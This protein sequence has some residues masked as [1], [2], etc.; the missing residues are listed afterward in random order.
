MKPKKF[1]LGDIVRKLNEEAAKE[2]KKQE[3]TAQEIG[4]QRPDGQTDPLPA[5]TIP[6]AP[7]QF[8]PLPARA[9]SPET[10]HI[11]AQEQKRKP[12][13]DAFAKTFN[14]ERGV[15]DVEAR[16]AHPQ[17]QPP[18]L[19]SRQ[20]QVPPVKQQEEDE[21][22]VEF[23]LFRYIGIILRRKNVIIAVTLA[24]ALFSVFQY[25]KGEKFYSAHARLL[26]KPEEKQIIGDQTYRY[27]GD[28][29]KAFSTHLELLKSNT[30]LAMVSDNLGGKVDIGAIRR[31]LT[32]AQGQ[33]NR[34]KND[35]IEL[36]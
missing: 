36:S 33:T 11:P 17:P 12:A 24:M 9:P 19:P 4:T 22:E 8:A 13:P 7:S 31:N 10:P 5:A 27:S 26:F 32:I 28:R 16:S 30:V 6:T 20:N 25:L 35:I 21:E 3:T 23:D 29:E 14:P 34:E 18:R 15:Q 2:D 1:S